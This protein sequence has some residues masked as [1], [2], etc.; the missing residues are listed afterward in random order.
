[1]WRR[2]GHASRRLSRADAESPRRTPRPALVQGEEKHKTISREDPR[3][4]Q[5]LSR[6][7]P[8]VHGSGEAPPVIEGA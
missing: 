2:D 5:V 6:G 7:N 1:M 3:R 4:T 8:A